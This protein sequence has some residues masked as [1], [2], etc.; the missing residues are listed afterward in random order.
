M[1]EPVRRVT[2]QGADGGGQKPLE[3]AGPAI[4]EDLRR[5]TSSPWAAALSAKCSA[6]CVR[7]AVKQCVVAHD[8]C[9]PRRMALCFL[10]PLDAVGDRNAR[11]TA[12]IAPHGMVRARHPEWR[13]IARSM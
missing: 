13:D 11:R 10:A 1:P 9:R 5:R 4:L 2:I 12:C 8:D 7:G 3:P 6:R